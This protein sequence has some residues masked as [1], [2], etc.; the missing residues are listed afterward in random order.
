MATAKPINPLPR[1]RRWRRIAALALLALLVLFAWL[2]SA[3]RG[4]AVTAAAVGARIGCGCRHIAGRPL[5]SCS[6]DFEPGM[7]LV[8]LSEDAE[9]KSVTARVPLMASETARFVAGQGCVPEPWDD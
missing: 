3:Q 2:W 1:R 7:G 4:N 5:D 9:S 6:R 8:F